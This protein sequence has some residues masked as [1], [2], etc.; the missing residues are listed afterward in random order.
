MGVLRRITTQRNAS[1]LELFGEFTEARVNTLGRE[2]E[3]R[4]TLSIPQLHAACSYLE[5]ESTCR[6]RLYIVTVLSPQD[7]LKRYHR[8]KVWIVPQNYQSNESSTS[9]L[10]DLDQTPSLKVTLGAPGWLS[11]LSVRLLISAPVMISQFVRLSLALGSILPARNLL[12][13]LSLSLS[14]FLCLYPARTFSLNT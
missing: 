1:G 3:T 9:L 12:G 10:R 8:I 11:R 13:I 5:A 4:V 14:L 7:T 6:A 2:V